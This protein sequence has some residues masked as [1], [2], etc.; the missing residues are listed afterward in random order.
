MEKDT[1]IKN[2]TNN[3]QK[4]T[5]FLFGT[6]RRF[7]ISIIVI[8]LISFAAWKIYGQETKQ[9]Q[10][11]ISTVEKGTIIQTVSESGNI[12]SGSQAGVGSPTTGI[13]TE[14]YVKNGD[15]V[16]KGQNLFKVQSIAS[17]QEVAQALASYQS[18]VVSAN[19]AS[20]NKIT[21][22]SK[23][24]ADRQA[25]LDAQGDVDTLNGNLGASRPNPATKSTYTQDEIESIKSKLTQARYTFTA[26]EQKYLE[27][28]QALAASNASKNSAWLAYQATQD[29]VV[30]APVDG[31]ISNIALMAGDQVT[32]SSGNLTSN[33]TTSSDTS[34]SSTNAVLYIS[35]FTTPY[36]KLQ[37]SEVDIPK[38]K[39]GQKAT[40]TL[41]AYEGKTYVG[42]VEQVDTAGTISSGVVTYNVFVSFLAP[43]D[44]LRPGMSATVNIETAKKDDVLYIPS[45]AVQKNN[46]Q[47]TVRILQNGQVTSV[48]VETGLTSDSD[49]EITSGLTEGETVVRSVVTSSSQRTFGGNSPFGGGFRT[50]GGGGRGG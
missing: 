6:S 45:A 5:K 39:P 48:P 44:N 29:S 12:A 15:T 37:A 50:F 16:T 26:D 25:I 33:R 43:P 36:I 49:T 30:I 18:T 31:T 40:I 27:S 24:E 2:K 8:I 11:Q 46:G 20:V 42:T 9:P 13:V 38:I 34:S 14:I 23:L 21:N 10:Y 41:D 35:N 4:I 22:Q 19:T 1:K 47:T 32:A 28:D 3:F 17:A 7:I